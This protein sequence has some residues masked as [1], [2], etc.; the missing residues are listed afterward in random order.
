[1]PRHI[2]QIPLRWADVDALGHVNNVAFLRYLQEARVEM[3]FV[4]AREQGTEQLAEG[5]VVAAH[6]IEYHASLPFRP[7]PVI[8]ETWVTAVGSAWFTLGYE[9]VDESMGAER[10]RVVCASA[11]SKLVPYSLTASRPRRLTSVEKA[12]LEGFRE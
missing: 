8:V 4:N 12:V 5:V 1:M 10:R 9:V 6:E 2:A 11:T 3:L 7:G